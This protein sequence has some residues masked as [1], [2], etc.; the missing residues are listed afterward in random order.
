MELYAEYDNPFYILL[1]LLWKF[2]GILQVTFAD[3][4]VDTLSA[5]FTI[6]SHIITES[7]IQLKNIYHSHKYMC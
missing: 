2:V 3:T 4:F 1:F 7:P 6:S 5:A